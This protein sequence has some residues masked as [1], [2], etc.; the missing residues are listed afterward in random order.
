VDP[1]RF[2]DAVQRTRTELAKEELL[3]QSHGRVLELLSSHER[4]ASTRAGDGAAKPEYLERVAVRVQDRFLLV[5]MQEVDWIESAANYVQL[6]TRSRAFMLRMTMGEL[7]EK[8]D[9]HH[10]GPDP[11]LDDRQRR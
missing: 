2:R 11:P 3:E 5:K 8:L 4:V 7:E 6:H 1:K 9:A 10:F